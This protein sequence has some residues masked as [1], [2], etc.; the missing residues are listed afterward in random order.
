MCRNKILKVQVTRSSNCLVSHF[1]TLCF[2]IWPN[3]G[4]Y[5]EEDDF[6]F[7]A[8]EK[9]LEEDNRELDLLFQKMDDACEWMDVFSD[10]ECTINAFNSNMSSLRQAIPSEEKHDNNFHLGILLVGII[11]AYESFIHD[12][13]DVCCNKSSYMKMAITNIDKLEDKDRNYLRLKVNSTEG[14]LR[15]R[16]KKATLHDPIQIARLSLV[17][18]NLRMPILKLEHTE[19]LLEQRNLFTH[20]G[21][22]SNGKQIEIKVENVLGVYNAIYKL[23]NEYINSISKDADLCLKEEI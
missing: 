10:L 9:E 19:K 14:F 11:S 20:H 12:F 2:R 22:I 6:D 15:G 1:K 4:V 8:F 3:K 18:F 21:G 16:L 17:F 13:F 23:V 5:M 7:E